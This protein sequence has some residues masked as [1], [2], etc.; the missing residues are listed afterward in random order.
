MKISHHRVKSLSENFLSCRT[1]SITVFIE[2]S[3]LP[4]PSQ[5]ICCAPT[6]ISALRNQEFSDLRI[7]TLANELAWWW[8][9]G[10]G[11]D[12]QKQGCGQHCP[13]NLKNS[14]QTSMWNSGETGRQK[15]RVQKRYQRQNTYFR[16]SNY[17]KNKNRGQRD[18]TGVKMRV[19]CVTD[20]DSIQV[21]LTPERCLE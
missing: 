16:N 21:R 1:F 12:F 6:G 18:S 7:Y 13:P 17:L 14:C 11:P 5:L 4:L 20:G 8:P 2:F 15:V 3:W 10:G 19:M 9:W